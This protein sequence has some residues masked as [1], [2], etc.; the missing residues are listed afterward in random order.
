MKHTCRHTHKNLSLGLATVTW[1]RYF[2]GHVS[3]FHVF[4]PKVGGALG[5]GCNVRY[6]AQPN[7]HVYFM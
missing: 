3:L 6:M 5:I 2:L 4:W 1:C 7:G